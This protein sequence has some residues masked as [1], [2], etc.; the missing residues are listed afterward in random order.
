MFIGTLTSRKIWFLKYLLSGIRGIQECP[1]CHSRKIK[2]FFK[3]ERGYKDEKGEKIQ[4]YSRVYQCL[5]RQCRKITSLDRLMGL[6]YIPRTTNPN[7]FAKIFA[8]GNKKGR[9]RLD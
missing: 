1:D 3:R 9:R 2:F 4:C 5:N 6:N 7:K 8:V